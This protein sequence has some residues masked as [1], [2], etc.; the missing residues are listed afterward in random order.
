MRGFKG[1]PLWQDVRIKSFV[2]KAMAILTMNA[3]F[4]LEITDKKD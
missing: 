2:R 4:R 1:S 3:E